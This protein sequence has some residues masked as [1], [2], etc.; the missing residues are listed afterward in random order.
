MGELKISRVKTF[1]LTFVNAVQVDAG[2]MRNCRNV[3]DCN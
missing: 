1:K 2:N 3:D